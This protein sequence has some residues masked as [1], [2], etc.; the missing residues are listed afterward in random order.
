MVWWEVA[1]LASLVS[2]R[3]GLPWTEPPDSPPDTIPIPLGHYGTPAPPQGAASCGLGSLSPVHTVCS[4]TLRHHPK[5]RGQTLGLLEA[6]R[7]GSLP[8]LGAKAGGPL[9][10]LAPGLSPTCSVCSCPPPTKG[11]DPLWKRP[12]VT[13]WESQHLLYLC[14]QRGNEAQASPDPASS[15]PCLCSFSTYMSIPAEGHVLPQHQHLLP[16]KASPACPPVSSPV[17][18]SVWGSRCHVRSLCSPCLW[19]SDP[20]SLPRLWRKYVFSHAETGL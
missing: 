8:V 13:L 16:G 3:W 17:P 19:P 5:P 2:V 1:G 20:L 7:G 14:S 15:A 18:G 4:A 12:W 11:L 6:V 10:I 9:C